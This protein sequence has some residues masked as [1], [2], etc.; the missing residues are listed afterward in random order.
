MVELVYR[1]TTQLCSDHQGAIIFWVGYV[2]TGYFWILSIT[3]CIYA[4][5]QS[6]HI[7][8]PAV[9]CIL[10]DMVNS[11]SMYL[12]LLENFQLVKKHGR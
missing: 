2:L 4:Y 8:K 9:L 11:T 7:S 10:V 3:V 5:F 12:V 6:F 1:G